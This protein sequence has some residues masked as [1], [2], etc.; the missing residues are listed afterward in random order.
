MLRGVRVECL[1]FEGRSGQLGFTKAQGEVFY[2]RLCITS[3]TASV[4]L[5]LPQWLDGRVTLPL[6]LIIPSLE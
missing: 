3:C 4:E 5:S 1:G 6:W 2:G